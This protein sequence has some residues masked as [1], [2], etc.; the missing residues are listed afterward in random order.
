MLTLVL[1]L[2]VMTPEAA[3]QEDVLKVSVEEVRIPCAAYDAGGRFD[4]TLSVDD[5]LVRE[6]GEPQ[7]VTGVYRVPAYVLL[8]A[9]TGGEQNP[10]KTARLTGDVA[11][12]LVLALRPGDGVAVMQVSGRAELI[13][14]WTNDLTAVVKS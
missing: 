4:P 9:D 2:C 13:H 1:T 11:A 5:L 7:R 8:L 3:A 10:V 6:D 14:G 12:G